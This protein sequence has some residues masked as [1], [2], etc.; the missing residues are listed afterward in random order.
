MDA[1][2]GSNDNRNGI[3]LASAGD[4]EIFDDKE[5]NNIDYASSENNTAIEIDNDIANDKDNRDKRQSWNRNEKER[6]RI[7]SKLY[8]NDRI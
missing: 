8:G 2:C 6:G 7:E 1:L 5:N 3:I 4:N